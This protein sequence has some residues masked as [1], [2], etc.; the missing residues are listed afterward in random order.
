MGRYYVVHT[1]H[2]AVETYR[3]YLEECPDLVEKARR[4]LAGKNLACWCGLDSEC[5]ADVLLDLAN[6]RDTGE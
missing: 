4:N 2:D 1:V 5:H 6:P 3:A